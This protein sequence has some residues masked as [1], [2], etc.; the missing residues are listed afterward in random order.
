[1]LYEPLK[2]LSN[3]NNDIQSGLAA[4]HRIYNILDTPQEITGAPALLNHP[5]SLKEQIEF[6]DLR[7]AYDSGREVIKGIN[8]T[9][10]AGNILALVGPSGGGKTTLVN[11]L[12]RFYEVSAGAVLLDGEDIRHFSLHHLRSQIA[13]VT[14]QTF[15]FNDTVRANISYAR[16]DA[17]SREILEV[18]AA[19][20]AMDFIERLPNGLDSVIGEA[21]VL[22]SGGE[23]Q[24]LSIARALLANRPI[25]ILDEA[26]SSLDTQSEMFVQKALE[27]LMQNRTT[28]VIAHRLSTVRKADRIAVITEGRIVEAGGHEQLLAQGGLYKSLHDMQFKLDA[29]MENMLAGCQES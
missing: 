21:G 8:L 18:A 1:M 9:V 2:R 27:N 26:T 25:L 24:R 6:R 23:R 13:I 28:L 12:P 20:Y 5:P 3:I 15:L 7:F 16:P 14:Q 22:L 11:L 10:P 29:G 17:S 19:A 4:G